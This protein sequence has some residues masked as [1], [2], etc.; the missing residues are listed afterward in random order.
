MWVGFAIN[1]ATGILLLIA[2]PTKAFTNPVFYVKLSMIA[3]GV[4]IMVKIKDRVFGNP[5]LNEEEMIARGKTM[6][7]WSLASWTG[8]ITAGRLLAYT[9][10]H[11]R[12]GL[13][14]VILFRL[15]F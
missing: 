6:A 1:A 2:Y 10:T 8:A 15:H 5:G 3:L 12:Y 4:I 9:F 14:G 13:E 7:K 11:L